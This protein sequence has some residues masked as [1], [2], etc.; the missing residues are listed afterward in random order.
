MKS[1]TGGLRSGL[2]VLFTA[3]NLMLAVAGNAGQ[4]GG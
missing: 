3:L 4:C 2:F 1:R